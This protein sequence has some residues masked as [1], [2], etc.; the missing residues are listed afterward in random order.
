MALT[1]SFRETV[2]KRVKDDPAFRAH[3]LEEALNCFL[4]GD[5]DTGKNLLRDYLNATES[6]HIIADKIETNVKSLQRMVGP[7]G[8]PTTRNLFLIFNACTSNEGIKIKACVTPHAEVTGKRAKRSLPK[9]A[10]GE[11]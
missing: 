4:A 9:H 8:N 10:C 2:Q 3:L 5:I 11:R 6:T 7:K 1:K